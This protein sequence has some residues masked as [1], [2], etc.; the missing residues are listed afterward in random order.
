[1]VL[2]KGFIE[3]IEDAIINLI[4]IGFLCSLDIQYIL[5]NHDFR[6]ECCQYQI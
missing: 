2:D 4:L 1:M 3:D 5:G 6:K